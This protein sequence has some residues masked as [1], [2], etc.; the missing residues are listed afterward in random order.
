[1]LL[2]K[3]DLVQKGFGW[4]LKAVSQSHQ[5]EIFDYVIEKKAIMSRAALKICH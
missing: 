4:M 1:L 5:K 2:E 3:D